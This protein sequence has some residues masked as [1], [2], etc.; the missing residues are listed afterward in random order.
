MCIELTMQL[1]LLCNMYGDGQVSA[2]LFI[3]ARSEEDALQSFV[4]C[5][6]QMAGFFDVIPL[7]SR[8]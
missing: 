6:M 4:G 7:Q 3:G 5:S 1:I 2:R 8:I